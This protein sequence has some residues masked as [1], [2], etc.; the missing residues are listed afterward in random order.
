MELK[1]S[2]K[3]LTLILIYLSGIISNSTTHF[4]YGKES[5]HLKPAFISAIIKGTPAFNRK[6]FTRI[7]YVGRSEFCGGVFINR[8]WI[9]TAASCLQNDSLGKFSLTR[10]IVSDQVRAQSYFCSDPL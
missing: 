10:I 8:R 2:A 5:A 9:L 3:M 7:R 6:F 4:N 1:L